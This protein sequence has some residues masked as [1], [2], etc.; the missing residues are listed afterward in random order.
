MLVTKIRLLTMIL[1]SIWHIMVIWIFGSCLAIFTRANRIMKTLMMTTACMSCEMVWM[2]DSAKILQTQHVLSLNSPHIL[3]L[4]NPANK[5]EFDT[6]SLRNLHSK[7]KCF[8]QR[9]VLSKSGWPQDQ[10]DLL[11]VK[12]LAQHGS[13]RS[14][15][16]SIYSCSETQHI[17]GNF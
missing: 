13:T 15:K 9:L 8:H 11:C 1:W 6:C 10:L 17:D 3:Y 14:S 16:S 12:T 4:L 2:Q 7:I 5:L